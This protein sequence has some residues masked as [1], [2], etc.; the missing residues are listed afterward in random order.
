MPGL[1]HLLLRQVWNMSKRNQADFRATRMEQPS[2][3]TG[4][5]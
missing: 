1:D 4:Y 2:Q 3:G 5:L